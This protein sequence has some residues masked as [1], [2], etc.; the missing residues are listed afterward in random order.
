MAS[1][2]DNSYDTVRTTIESQCQDK[3]QKLQNVCAEL[4]EKRTSQ[5]VEDETDLRQLYQAKENL[6]KAQI[7]Q[8]ENCNDTFPT[9]KVVHRELL[10][11]ELT[12]SVKQLEESKSLSHTMYIEAV[13]E[14]DKEKQLNK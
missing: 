2:E 12:K 13:A 9:E 4:Q 14:L 6:L 8:L 3:W 7:Q 1:S 11:E 5:A 10:L